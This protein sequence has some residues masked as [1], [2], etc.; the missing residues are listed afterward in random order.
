MKQDIEVSVYIF[1]YLF[2]YLCFQKEAWQGDEAG[3]QAVCLYI[4]LFI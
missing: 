3:H 2:K 4:Q 1:S